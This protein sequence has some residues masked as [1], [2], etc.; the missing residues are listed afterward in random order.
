MLLSDRPDEP[1]ARLL[2]QLKGMSYAVLLV[3]L[4]GGLFA[5]LG[6]VPTEPLLSELESSVKCLL[7]DRKLMSGSSVWHN[8]CSWL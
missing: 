2:Q 1:D 4:C 3:S 5:C 8:L 6:L 7:E